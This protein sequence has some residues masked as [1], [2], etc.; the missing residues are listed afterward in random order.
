M[1][2]RWIKT[3]VIAAKYENYRLAAERLYLAQPTVTMHIQHL[4]KEM[5][6]KLFEKVGR[7]V[8]LTRAGHRFLPNARQLLDS[9]RN[10]MTELKNWQQGYEK[11][12]V[13]AVSPLIAGS[14][15]PFILQQFMKNYPS[16]NVVIMVMESNE[17]GEAISTGKAD[18]GLSRMKPIQSDVTSYSLYKDPVILVAPHTDGDWE[19]PP[20]DIDYLFEQFAL[21]T[22]NHPVYWDDLLTEIRSFYPAA[23]TMV[24]TQSVVTVRFI[25]EGL[26]FSFLPRSSVQRELLEGRLLEVDIPFLQMP[27][28]STY[29]VKKYEI[30]E[31]ELFETFLKDFYHLK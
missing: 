27:E 14:I 6:I 8:Q 7:N 21:F 12:L 10:S 19:S 26:G 31:A 16:V 24:I 3:F 29:V 1:D 13:L 11:K 30:Q 4:E 20:P 5:G 9:Y 22:H 23:R 28:A 2:I 25:E 18:F 17:I 15:L